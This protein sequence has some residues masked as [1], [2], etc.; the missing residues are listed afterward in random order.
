MNKQMSI[1]I[2]GCNV[3][4]IGECE[5]ADIGIYGSKSKLFI[6]CR[7]KHI[8]TTSIKNGFSELIKLV[9]KY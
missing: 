3:N 4:G 6:Y 7:G 8:K 9:N 1:A 5:H 2:M